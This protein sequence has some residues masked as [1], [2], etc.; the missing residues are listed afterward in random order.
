MVGSIIA[1]PLLTGGFGEFL[2]L[3]ITLNVTAMH[4][5]GSHV[6]R[7]FYT[8]AL[9]VFSVFGPGIHDDCLQSFYSLL[10]SM[11]DNKEISPKQPQ[12]LQD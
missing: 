2:D 10:V 1:Y 8:T 4:R 9:R 7:R 6:Y 11:A 5:S 3:N 12:H